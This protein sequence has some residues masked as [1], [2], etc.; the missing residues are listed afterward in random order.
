[1]GVGSTVYSLLKELMNIIPT[2]EM[3]FDLDGIFVV[4]PIPDGQNDII[5]PIDETQYISNDLSVDFQN[6][7]NQVVVYGKLNN[8]DYFTQNGDNAT[9]VVIDFNDDG[10]TSTLKLYYSAINLDTVTISGTNFGFQGPNIPN[11]RPINSVEIY[12]N[13]ELVCVATLVRFENS[14]S[15]FGTE[16]S[17]TYLESFAIQPNELYFI[18]IYDARVIKNGDGIEKVDFS[19]PITYEFMGKQSPSYC[20]VNTNKQSPFYINKNYEGPNYYVGLAEVDYDSLTDN[21]VLRLPNTD[22]ITSLEN[23]TII[24]FMANH[25]SVEFQKVN[26]YNSQGRTII[27]D[28]LIVQN[29]WEET[30]SGTIRRNP[31]A[32]GKLSNDYTIWA[33]E[34]EK[35]FNRFVLLGR[36]TNALTKV[37]SGGEYDNIYSDQLAYERCEYELFLAS[38][39]KDSITLGVVPNYILDVN[40]KIKYNANSALPLLLKQFDSDS[41]DEYYMIKQISYPLGISTTSQNISAIRIYNDDN[42]I[43]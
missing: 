23:G 26:I 30:L 32:I 40:N 13:Q 3:F 1:M 39:M 31:I 18:R 43:K 16:Y 25:T 20:L 19:S 15:S 29:E 2:W 5:Y 21:Y 8:I 35:K 12:N 7:K 41:E 4:R 22:D 17:D 6:V 37:C 42:I 24:T 36:H 11:F 9:N 33:L 27:S 34:Y 14:T 28:A 38:N 10:I